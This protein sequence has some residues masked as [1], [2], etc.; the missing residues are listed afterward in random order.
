MTSSAVTR[1]G[2]EHVLPGREA[3]VGVNIGDG[4]RKPR[5]ET[6]MVP[7]ATFTS[8]YGRPILKEPTWKAPDI[9]GYFFC[10]GLAGAAS[11]FAAAADVTGRHALSR[12]AKVAA[13]GSIA[14]GMAGLVHDLGR[15]A[16]FMNML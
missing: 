11:V 1:E 5:A 12:S 8:Y 2:L 10:G 14:V 4:R 7:D 15:P 6:P 16:R 13:A 3:T 9:P